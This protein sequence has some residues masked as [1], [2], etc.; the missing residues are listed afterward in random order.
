M[1]YRIRPVFSR[2]DSTYATTTAGVFPIRRNLEKYIVCSCLWKKPYSASS[3]TFLVRAIVISSLPNIPS[4][5]NW[6]LLILILRPIHTA[7]ADATQLSSWV[8]SASRRRRK[9]GN[10]TCWEFIL[11][12]WVELRCRRC[13]RASRL[14]WPS[15][16]FCSLYVTVA[17]NWKLGHDW[18]LVRSHRRHDAT[19]LSCR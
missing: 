8:A 7:D 19:R 10:W 12:S 4:M 6:V 11:S 15:L 14:S 18:R 2:I 3:I 5:Q 13:V 16:Q 9:F 17:E 1:T